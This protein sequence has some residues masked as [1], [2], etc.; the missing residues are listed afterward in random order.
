MGG[1]LKN[2]DMPT[3]TNT[4]KH[5]DIK[6]GGSFH[7]GNVIYNNTYSTEKTVA[8]PKL[9]T[10][11]IPTDADHLLGRAKELATI[12]AY[13]KQHNP[14]VLLN[15]I[16]G[17]GKTAVATKYIVLYGHQYAHIAWLTV[18]SD[19]LSAF[20]GNSIFIEA[21]GMTQKV[22]ELIEAKKA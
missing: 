5:A 15:G 6:V 14:T 19:V 10:N 4:N 16:G 20:I 21:L 13:F 17:I 7:Q 18:N 11:Y 8:I 3:K 22:T 2:C 12:N 1:Y 9:L